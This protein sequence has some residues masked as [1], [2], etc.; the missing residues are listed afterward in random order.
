LRTA[1]RFSVALVLAT[2]LAFSV[3]PQPPKTAEIPLHPARAFGLMLV[4]ARINGQPAVLILDTGSNHTIVSTK[5]VDVSV[6]ALKNLVASKKGSGYSGNGVFTTATVSVGPA[7]WRDHPIVAMDTNE[8]SKSMGE[9]V[10]GM[11]GTDFLDE[12]AA[13]ID[14]RQHK[15]IL[16][17]SPK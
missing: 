15:L 8:L 3:S 2:A 6:P 5:F 17:H 16:M 12:F 9:S 11:L 4:E 14:F 1:C 10:D 7:L 13:V